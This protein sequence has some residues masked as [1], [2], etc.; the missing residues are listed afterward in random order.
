MKPSDL[1][2]LVIFERSTEAIAPSGGV[3]RVWAEIARARAELV[4]GGATEEQKDRGA[5]SVT[6]L[7][8]RARY[9]PGITLADRVI[10]G[11]SAFDIIG[12]AEIGRRE[13]LEIRLRRTG[14]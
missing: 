1:T 11:G 14:P 5:V 10:H 7:T 4:E 2:H 13:A 9:V 6:A 3:D 12:L 8:F